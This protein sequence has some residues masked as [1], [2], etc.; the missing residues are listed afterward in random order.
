MRN[1]WLVRIGAC[2]WPAVTERVNNDMKVIRRATDEEIAEY[3]KKGVKILEWKQQNP[4]Y[5]PTRA[6]NG[7]G[8]N[9]PLVRFEYKGKVFIID[10][11]GCG[12]FGEDF[13]IFHEGKAIGGYSDMNAFENG[14]YCE[15]SNEFRYLINKLSS[16]E[17]IG[18]WF[19]KIANNL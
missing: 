13:T 14:I 16:N 11:H 5:D 19:R 15:M 3:L 12:D 8:Y 10:D 17:Y 7:G 6:N 1:Y 9:Q 2:T 4:H 18:W